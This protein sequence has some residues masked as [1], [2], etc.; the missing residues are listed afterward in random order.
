M[1][2]LLFESA[3][4]ATLIITSAFT[5]AT[6]AHAETSSPMPAA[7]NQLELDQRA[8][9]SLVA[10]TSPDP[11]ERAAA[12]CEL[13]RIG[14]R[15]RAAIPQLIALMAD[16]TPLPSQI[17]CG[18]QPP[19]EDESW[20]PDH[21]EVLEPSPGEA[22]TRALLGMG[23]AAIAPLT[24]TLV[25]ASHWRARKN[26]A[27]ALAHRGRAT[28][29]LINA[30]KDP[31]WQVRTEAAYALFQRGGSSR[32]VIDAL[33]SALLDNAWQVR[34]QATLAL[35][36]KGGGGTDVVESLLLA[37]SDQHSRVRVAATVVLWHRADLRAW[38]ALLGA[39]RDPDEGVRSG[40]ARALGNRARD[41]E[42]QLL[43]AARHDPDQ[44]IREGVRE[45]LRIV[46]ERMRGT[47]TNLTRIQIPI[48]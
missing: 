46:D 11:A 3:L 39:L 8:S 24:E 5:A 45:A 44:H 43:I 31:A 29:E 20:A 12:A 10:L 23:D 34:E 26:A 41:P 37:L 9:T 47:T 48:D 25:G 22:A 33:S 21:A 16:G 19:F 18:T 30:L 15:A 27:W 35:G 4:R 40:A 2:S 7:Q 32:Q 6:L 36:N 28:G 17:F 14:G 13:G 1:T 38:D 42:V